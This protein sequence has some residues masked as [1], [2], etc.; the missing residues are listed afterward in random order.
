MSPERHS[1]FAA[2]LTI[3]TEE[4]EDGM[5]DDSQGGLLHRGEHSFIGE[6]E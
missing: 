5:L 1:D 6:N 2:A 3:W 4:A